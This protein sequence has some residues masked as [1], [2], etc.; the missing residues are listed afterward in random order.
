MSLRS[1]MIR[2]KWS[3]NPQALSEKGL[4]T[5]V[6][7]PDSSCGRYWDKVWETVIPLPSVAPSLSTARLG[8]YRPELKKF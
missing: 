8:T 3:N 5:D 2:A 6:R 7:T 4:G 1:L